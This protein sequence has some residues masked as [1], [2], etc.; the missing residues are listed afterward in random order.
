MSSSHPLLIAWTTLC[1]LALSGC[2][3]CEDG[4][5]GELT[6][7]AQVAPIALEL[8]PTPVGVRVQ[9]VLTLRNVGSAV[10][11]VSRIALDGTA[12]FVLEGAPE[13]QPV[14][15]SG[16]LPLIISARPTMVGTFETTLWIDHAGAESPQTVVKVRLLAVEPPPCDD[17]NTCTTD[18]FDTETA[19]CVH[20]FAD[21]LACQPADRCV[22]DA[23][24]QQGVCLGAQKSCSDDSVCTRDVCRQID[25]ECRF[26][27]D[28]SAC[29]DDNP[30]TVDT[31][32]PEGCSHTPQPNG[33]ACDDGDACTRADACFAGACVGTGAA[34]GQVCDDGDSC[35]VG[36]TC[37]AGRCTGQSVITAA[38]AEGSLVFSY[39]L[40]AWPSAFMH[41]REVSLRDD[42]VFVGMDHLPLTDPPGLSH[43][44]FAMK[45]CGT[46]AYEFSYRPP[47]GHVYVSYVR[48]EMQLAPDGSLRI[49]VGIRQTRDNG[50][51]PE[52]TSY[53]LDAAGQATRSIIQVPGGETG[54]SLLPD[55]SHIYGTVWP[56]DEGPIGQD[57][58]PRTNLIVVREDQSGNVLWQHERTSG[59]WAE[60]LGT[61]GPRVLFWAS[62]SW[63]ALDFNTG[64]VVWS[65]RTP[66]IAD[67]MALST[68]LN[69]GLARVGSTGSAFFFSQP[70]QVVGVEILLGRQVFVYPPTEDLAY[71]PRTDPVIAADGRIILLMQRAISDPRGDYQP[72][73]LDFVE[74][75]S[76]GEVLST[77]PLPYSFPR[78]FI[79]TR[80]RDL[81]DDPYPTVAD[82]GVTYVGYGEQFWAIDPGG[83]IRWTYTST[84]PDAFTATVPLLRD[85]GVVLVNE[86]ARRVIGLRTNG[87][88]MSADGWASFRH[89]GRRTNH[90][91]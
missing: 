4:A 45:Q 52:T 66:Y 89:D 78:G 37:A 55:G 54:R 91:P 58:E 43:V 40:K 9:G 24:C 14:P 50:F 21:G 59:H 82:D 76:G 11:E 51:L 57:E 33:E 77:T 74:L 25:G 6:A 30:C 68:R 86:G 13:A 79:E 38:G 62:D 48:R 73:G 49:V 60:F 29:D 56:L 22:I 53:L 64:S 28:A 31:C 80:S 90:T 20:S 16:S 34:D 35:T 12:P 36:D 61:A 27:E 39:P 84:L 10:L 19:A 8:G 70:T 44:I 47:D 85:D 46:P 88:R 75:T 65:S 17:G 72:V 87:G 18:V 83:Q 63:G 23:V 81:G 2:S 3:A 15:P 7:R 26:I 32:G 71:I 67:Q 69:L 5:V 41:R 42:G 1:A